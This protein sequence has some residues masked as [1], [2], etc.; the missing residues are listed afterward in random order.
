M[1]ALFKEEGLSI[2]IE[3]NVIETEFLDV[4]FN[5]ATKK[6]LPFRKAN[7][8]PICINALSNHPS[9]IIKQLPKMMSKRISDLR[10]N[11]TKLKLSTNQH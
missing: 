4:I 8:T 6:Y 9:T 3:A 11:S 5:L 7:N 10:K 2:T 1:I